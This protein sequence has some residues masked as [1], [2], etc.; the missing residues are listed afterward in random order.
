MAKQIA[1][2]ILLPQLYG[3]IIRW[4]DDDQFVVCIGNREMIGSK[5][6]WRI[7]NGDI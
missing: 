7:D 1:H 2:S 6:Y 3:E 5:K 4:L